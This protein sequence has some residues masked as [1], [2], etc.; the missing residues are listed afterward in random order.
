M[1]SGTWIYLQN[2]QCRRGHMVV[3]RERKK[4]IVKVEL[5]IA[6]TTLSKGMSAVRYRI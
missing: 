6:E 4:D 3:Y 2:V 1:R 5:S